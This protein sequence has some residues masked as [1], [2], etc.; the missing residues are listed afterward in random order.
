M[1]MLVMY[2]IFILLLLLKF[3]DTVDKHWLC[4]Y[5]NKSILT[6]TKRIC[7]RTSIAVAYLFIKIFE[8]LF[9]FGLKPSCLSLT[10]SFFLTV[11]IL[12]LFSCALDLVKN[13][14]GRKVKV[15]SQDWKFWM[16]KGQR[17]GG[18]PHIFPSSSFHNSLPPPPPSKF[19]ID[20]CTNFGSFIL[21]GMEAGLRGPLGLLVAPPVELASKSASA[22]AVTQALGTEAVCVWDRTEKN[23]RGL[24][25]SPS[26]CSSLDPFLFQPLH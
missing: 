7:P 12:D 18:A 26:S 14:K 1:I 21:T 8:P 23:G 19:Q 4:K 17:K 24:S 10:D 3:K 6:T 5:L 16:E 2:Q 25:H 11:Y 9:F 20:V 22:P 13:T 15:I